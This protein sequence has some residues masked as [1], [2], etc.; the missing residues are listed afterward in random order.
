V[1]NK[2]ETFYIRLYLWLILTDFY[3][4]KSFKS[5]ICAAQCTRC[6]TSHIIILSFSYIFW[7]TLAIK[8]I[9]SCLILM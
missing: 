6:K 3:R 5:R 4:F 8:W 7:H 1:G 2:N 9:Y